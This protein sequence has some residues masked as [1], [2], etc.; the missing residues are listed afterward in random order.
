MACTGPEPRPDRAQKI[1]EDFLE[2]LKTKHSVFKFDNS[3]QV[4]ENHRK[5]IL[6]RLKKLAEEIEYQ[7][8]CENW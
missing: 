4:F 5:E 7:D 6:A 1:Y 3:L 2:V 8:A